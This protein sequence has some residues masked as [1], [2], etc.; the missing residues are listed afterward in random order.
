MC[1]MDLPSV[2]VC[3]TLTTVVHNYQLSKLDLQF[4]HDNFKNTTL[5]KQNVLKYI[6]T[7]KP[8]TLSLKVFFSLMET[9]TDETQDKDTVN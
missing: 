8:I 3:G 9:E 1:T 7:P 4:K 5:I 2:Q 6:M